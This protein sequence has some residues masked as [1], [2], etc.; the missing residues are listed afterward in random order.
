MGLSN[1]LMIPGIGGRRPLLDSYPGAAVAYSL[2][3]LRTAYSGNCI[4]VRRSSDS[5]EQDIGFAPNGLLDATSL[6]SFVG[7]GDG[8]ITTWYDQVGSNNATSATTTQQPLIVSSGGL[9][10]NEFGKPAVNFVDNS[11]GVILNKLDFA[12]WY[13][14]NQSYVGYFSVY[15][16]STNG[17]SPYPVGSD[18]IDRGFITLHQTNNGLFRIGSARSVITAGSSAA[19]ITLNSTIARHDVAN[20]IRLKTFINKDSASVID[21]SD[22]NTDF[23]MPSSMMIGNSSATTIQCNIR[24]SELI[25][26]TVDQTAT[27][28]AIRSS[29]FDFWRS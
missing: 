23:A 11:G 21:L 28:L 29:Q 14:A 15:S 8:F 7:A 22:S 18:P 16:M 25:G 1:I 6:L 27:E 5:T 20:R 13:A 17:S 12:N 3:K 26:F 4:R 10:V 19:P 9:V 2:R 24:M